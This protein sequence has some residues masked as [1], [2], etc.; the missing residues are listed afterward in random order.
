MKQEETLA[1]RL[2][3]FIQHSYVLSKVSEKYNRLNFLT[4]LEKLLELD[5]WMMSHNFNVNQSV[6]CKKI[7][8][9]KEHLHKILPSTYNTSYEKSL[10]K[11]LEMLDEAEEGKD[12]IQHVLKLNDSNNGFRST[13]AH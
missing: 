11:L 13:Q 5:K 12:P 7:I 6:L 4:S 9:H 8:S 2:H 3:K 1:I 10:K